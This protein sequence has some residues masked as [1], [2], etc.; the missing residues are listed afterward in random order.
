MCAIVLSVGRTYVAVQEARG[1]SS[2]REAL[3]AF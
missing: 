2:G 3:V 1:Q